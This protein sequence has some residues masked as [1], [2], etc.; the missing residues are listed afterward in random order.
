MAKGFI[1]SNVGTYITIKISFYFFQFS[2]YQR[3]AGTQ[4]HEVG[5]TVMLVNRSSDGIRQYICCLF[6]YQSSDKRD[7]WFIGVKPK[8]FCQFFFI[9]SLSFFYR[10]AII[11][12]GNEQIGFGIPYISINS[13]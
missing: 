6:S 2:F 8:P 4:N 11:I 10:M 1:V 9:F 7:K 12:F 13:I 5:V 3:I